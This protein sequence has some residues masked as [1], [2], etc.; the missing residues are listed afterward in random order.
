MQLVGRYRSHAVLSVERA[1]LARHG[2]SVYNVLALMNGDPAVPVRLTAAGL[3]QARALGEAL[4]A[5]A[6]ELCVTSGFER[7]RTTADEALAR[8]R[9]SRGSSSRRSTTRSTAPY[10]GTLPRRLPRLGVGAPVDRRARAAAGESRVAIV[11]RYARALPP[12]ARA[13]GGDDPR[14]RALAPDRLR[15]RARGG[16]RP[17]ARTCRSSDTRRAYPFSAAELERRPRRARAAGS[18][19]RRW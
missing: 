16:E 6:L 17:G 19:R 15:A 11:E 1:I 3:A 4:A 7:A 9:R 10:E 2:E 18:P 13:A 8:P 5:S 12:A 14:R